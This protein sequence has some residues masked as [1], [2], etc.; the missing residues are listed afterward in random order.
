MTTTP[1]D[2]AMTSRE[3][4]RQ[5]ICIDCKTARHSPGRPRCDDCHRTYCAPPEPPPFVIELRL[6]SDE[7]LEAERV[8]NP[9]P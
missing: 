1:P 6:I 7:E 2:P 9:A 8:A 4:H 3:A 5:G